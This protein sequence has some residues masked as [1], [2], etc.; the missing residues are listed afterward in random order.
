VSGNLC[1]DEAADRDEAPTQGWGIEERH[2]WDDAVP[3]EGNLVEGNLCHG[4]VHGDVRRAG[5][6]G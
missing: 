4:H 6:Q 1:Y 3:S 2:S 5:G